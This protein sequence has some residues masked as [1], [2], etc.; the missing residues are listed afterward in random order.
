MINDIAARGKGNGLGYYGG[1]RGFLGILLN[2][3]VRQANIELAG[4]WEQA[5]RSRSNLINCG[6]MGIEVTLIVIRPFG[7]WAGGK[8]SGEG[9]C[10]RLFGGR[11]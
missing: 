8:M 1:K 3:G 2:Q 4:G 5:K 7:E 11:S 9:L 6:G 10:R